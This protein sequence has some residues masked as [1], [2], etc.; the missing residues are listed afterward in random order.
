MLLFK[1]FRLILTSGGGS[2][3]AG[4]SVANLFIITPNSFAMLL[5]STTRLF[6]ICMLYIQT[7]S[8]SIY[9]EQIRSKQQ[10]VFIHIQFHINIDS[11]AVNIFIPYSFHYCSRI[12][13]LRLQQCNQMTLSYIK[14]IGK[15]KA[16]IAI[17]H[18]FI[19]QI[20]ITIED[21]QLLNT[22]LY[23]RSLI[24]SFPRRN[25]SCS[26]QSLPLSFIQ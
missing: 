6:S 24:Q 15:L 26:K 14:Y 4:I 13:H 8:S 7:F 21:N 23:R 5:L 9:R 25:T 16:E 2:I 22:S 3:R 19:T 10:L 1:G 12:S 18:E 11:H 17:K 20:T